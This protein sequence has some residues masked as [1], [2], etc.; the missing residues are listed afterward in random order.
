[1]NYIM[2]IFFLFICKNRRKLGPNIDYRGVDR[3][4]RSKVRK[5]TSQIFVGDANKMPILQSFLADLK[6]D[7]DCIEE[8]LGEIPSALHLQSEYH[9]PDRL[10]DK[11][12]RVTSSLMENGFHE[13]Y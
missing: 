12:N 10:I 8:S 3:T 13:F 11:I 5:N 4:I 7:W 2:I 9:I 6:R 1:M